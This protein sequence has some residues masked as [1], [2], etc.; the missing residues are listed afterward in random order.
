MQGPLTSIAIALFDNNHSYL[1]ELNQTLR[2]DTVS[3]SA[4]RDLHI[5]FRKAASLLYRFQYYDVASFIENFDSICPQYGSFVDPHLTQGFFVARTH[6]FL[7]S[8][9]MGDYAQDFLA[10]GMYFANEA[11]MAIPGSYGRSVW[12]AGGTEVLLPKKSFA[13]TVA[14]SVLLGLQIALLLGFLLYGFWMPRWTDT[15]DAVALASIGAQLK[16]R[17]QFPPLG[18]AEANELLQR[19]R[20]E[21]GLVGLVQDAPGHRS[22]PGAEDIEMG[23]VAASESR[24]STATSRPHTAGVERGLVAHEL[25]RSESPVPH[26]AALHE[27]DPDLEAARATSF[28]ALSSRTASPP[29]PYL[30][31]R[32]AD[33]GAV[34][35]KHGYILAVGAPGIISRRIYKTEMRKR[36]P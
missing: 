8:F 32:S 2:N 24:V 6:E 3:L 31:S 19:L 14:V 20:K 35:P 11:S 4:C 10:V 23:G 13:A 29:P 7:S 5:P 30:A 25:E 22:A 26:P 17:V 33:G 1:S 34:L 12:F 27:P 18:T 9:G 36:S 21:D 15:L 28:A 16:D